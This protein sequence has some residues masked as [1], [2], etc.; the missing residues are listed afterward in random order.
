MDAGL[1]HFRDG[2]NGTLEFT[3][4]GASII[5]MF[6]EIRNAKVGFVKDFISDSSCFGKSG[7]GHLEPSSATLAFRNQNV[8]PFAPM[9]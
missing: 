9:R 2:H 3:F 8:V 5:H 6:R 7:A 1:L 4:H